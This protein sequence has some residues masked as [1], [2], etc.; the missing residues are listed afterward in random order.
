VAIDD[1]G[2]GFSSMSRL[3][4]LPVDVLKID[5]EFV[6]DVADDDIDAQIV[7][8]LLVLAGSLGLHVIAE[9]VETVAQRDRLAA[10]GCGWAQGFLWS[11]PCAPDQLLALV[12]EHGGN[13]DGQLG[14]AEATLLDIESVARRRVSR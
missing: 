12:R 1:F 7:A 13:L 14:P 5:R 2:T 3:K 9:G 4:H 10:L 8:S 6:V 11:R